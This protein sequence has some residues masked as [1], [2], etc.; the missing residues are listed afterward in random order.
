MKEEEAERKYTEL[1]EYIKSL[2]SVAVAFSGGVDSTLL[3]RA[4]SDTLK[5]RAIAVTARSCSFPARELDEARQYCSDHGI[6]HVI[7]DSEELDIPGFRHNP[8]NRCYLCKH[9]LFEK[10]LAMAQKEGIEN[11]AE[12]SNMDDNG[13][14]RPGLKAIAELGI[15]SPLRHVKLYKEEIRYLSRKLGLPTWRKQSFACLSSRFVYGEE[16]TEEKLHMV[17]AAEELLMRL[18]FEQLR[19]RIHGKLARIEVQPQD[20]ERLMSD[21]IREAV[22]YKLKQLGFDYVTVDM[23]GYRTGSMNETL[24]EDTMKEYTV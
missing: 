15:K 20:I 5:D 9:E 6:R 22:Y 1:C 21:G 11:V 2:N 10:M 8:V 16:I 4:A 3:L 13:D 14:F 18:G 23:M 17:D 24:S 12:G 7:V 19:V